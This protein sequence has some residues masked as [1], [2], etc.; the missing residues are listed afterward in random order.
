M[1]CD[2]VLGIYIL[3][4]P[5]VL[6][7]LALFWLWVCQPKQGE[8]RVV[9]EILLPRL[10]PLT[11]M[12][13]IQ[14]WLSSSM[15]VPA[16]CEV[17]IAVHLELQ[18]HWLISSISLHLSM[19]TTIQG[20][21][22]FTPVVSKGFINMISWLESLSIIKKEEGKQKY[23]IGIRISGVWGQSDLQSKFQYSQDFRE[24]L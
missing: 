14:S 12:C 21:A 15:S 20:A 18:G 24:K 22:N 17:Y 19:A 11:I 8:H 4:H 3:A 5:K 23:S 1:F 13:D 9:S 2:A 10:W 7:C 16:R 6:L